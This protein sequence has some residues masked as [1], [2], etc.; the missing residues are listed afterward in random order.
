MFNEIM[1]MSKEFED[2]K[3]INRKIDKNTAGEGC[4]A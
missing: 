2:K 1:V 4:W 3:I